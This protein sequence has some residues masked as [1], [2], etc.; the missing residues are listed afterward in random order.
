MESIQVYLNSKNCDKILTSGYTTDIEFNLPMI[1][2]EEDLHIYLSVQHCLIPYSFY[3][4]N[5]SNNV[6]NYTSNSVDY[7]IIIPVGNY[8][9]NQLISALLILMDGFTIVYNNLQ[10][11]L[12]FTH[13]TYDY[14]FLSTSTCLSLIGFS[15]AATS[16]SLILTSTMCINVNPINCIN[17]V[18]NLI[19]YS[20]NKAFPNNSSI[21]CSIPVNRPPYSLIEYI[22]N[23]NFRSNLFVNQINNIRIKL[24]DDNGNL[25][26]LNGLDFTMT[27]QLDCERFT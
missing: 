15:T 13:T 25:L 20:V 17:V 26:N 9:I 16:T 19:T 4:I 27:L 12:T 11:T 3:N 21:L 1:E 7:N 8:N 23:N 24:V 10:N 6:L 18:S 14:T 22:N 2:F 5:S